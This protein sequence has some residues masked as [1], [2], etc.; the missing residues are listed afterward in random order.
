MFITDVMVEFVKY[1]LFIRQ[2]CS[3]E[4][5]CLSSDMIVGSRELLLALGWLIATFNILENIVKQ[6]VLESPINKELGTSKLEQVSETITRTIAKVSLI[7]IYKFIFLF[8]I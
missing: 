7:F 1:Q 4:F 3:K 5:Y 6:K 2:Y 8:M